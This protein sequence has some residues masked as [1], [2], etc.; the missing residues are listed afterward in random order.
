MQS[1]PAALVSRSASV[2]N[3]RGMGEEKNR[4][5]EWNDAERTCL[6]WRRGNVTGMMDRV[7]RLETIDMA[8][9]EIGLMVVI[10]ILCLGTVPQLR[11]LLRVLPCVRLHKAPLGRSPRGSPATA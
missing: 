2:S 5:R 7:A 9:H 11:L 8:L 10:V 6:E 1:L 3:G 4:E